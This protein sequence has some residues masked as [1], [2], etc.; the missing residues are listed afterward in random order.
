LARV[1]SANGAERAAIASVLDAQARGDAAALIAALDGCAR[2][3]ACRALAARNATALRSPGAVKIIRLDLSSG[4]SPV[5][6]TGTARVVWTAP[7]RTTVVQCARVRRDGDALRGLTVTV[8]ALSR[9][10]A[11]ASSC[12]R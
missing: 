6:S 2:R 9:P 12:P 4:F 8:V 3:P 7:G 1:L 11:R 5:G 10:I